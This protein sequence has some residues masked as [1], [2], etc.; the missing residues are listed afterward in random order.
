MVDPARG[1]LVVT[2]ASRGIGAAIAR[3]AGA[4]GYD[5]C[6]NFVAHREHADAVVHD[7]RLAGRAAIAVQ[8]DVS[9]AG[10]VDWMFEVAT[11]ELGP[12]VGLVNNA[13]TTG[14]MA[15]LAEVSAAQLGRAFA[16]NALG[17]L[18]CMQAA[19]RCFRAAPRRGGAIVNLSSTV[20]RTTGAGEWVHYAASKAALDALTRGAARELAGEAI[21]VNAV[22][23]GLIQTDLHVDNGQPDRPERLRSSVPMRRIGEPEEVAHAVMWLLSSEASYVTGAVIEVSGGR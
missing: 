19:I 1:V 13:G 14:G 17:A 4:Q 18:L 15:P 20:V 21:R 8:A 9:D 7:I 5:V 6:V 22:A 10:A 23:P 12:V 11:R 16:V 3:L 2:G